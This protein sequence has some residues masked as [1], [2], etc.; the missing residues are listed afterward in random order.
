MKRNVWEVDPGELGLIARDR[1]GDAVCLV[2][3]DECEQV[4]TSFA[5]AARSRRRRC[6]APWPMGTPNGM[7]KK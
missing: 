4:V 5:A 3:K 2:V 6:G 1:L 7:D